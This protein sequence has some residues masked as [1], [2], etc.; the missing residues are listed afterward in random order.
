MGSNDETDGPLAYRYGPG[1]AVA[2]VYPEMCKAGLH[3]LEPGKTVI[4]WDPPHRYVSCN[5]CWDARRPDHTWH[6]L[7]PSHE[8]FMRQWQAHAKSQAT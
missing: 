6:L 5:R 3:R 2:E 1:T 7:P 8:E 4:G